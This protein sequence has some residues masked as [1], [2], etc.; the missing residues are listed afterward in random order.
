MLDQDPTLQSHNTVQ[1]YLNTLFNR[2]EI[3]KEEYT[4]KICTNR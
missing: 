3:S 4:T 1:K 2:G